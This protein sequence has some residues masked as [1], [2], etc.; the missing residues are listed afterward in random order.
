MAEK[1]TIKRCYKP[2]EP[3]PVEKGMKLL[4]EIKKY[5]QR[6]EFVN[7]D[8]LQTNNPLDMNRIDV[9]N[10]FYNPKNSVAIRIESSRVCE[11]SDWYEEVYQEIKPRVLLTHVIITVKGNE[12]RI[13]MKRLFLAANI[14]LTAKEKI[15]RQLSSKIPEKKCKAVAK[16]NLHITLKFLGYLPEQ[17]VQ[18]LVEKLQPLG[19][20][21]SFKAVLRGVGHFRGRVLWLGVKEGAGEL[22]EISSEIN[23]LLEIPGEKFSA[24]IT[25]ARNKFAYKILCVSGFFLLCGLLGGGIPLLMV[26]APIIGVFL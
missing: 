8:N 14:P 17:S 24:H 19:K 6:N 5:L 13:E 12:E 9:A 7:V 16:E 22:K 21:K 23:K 3:F 11:P 15:F 1:F 4:N 18:E 20:K 2:T 25:I 26:G 10:I